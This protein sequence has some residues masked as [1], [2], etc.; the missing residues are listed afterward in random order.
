LQNA[1]VAFAFAIQPIPVFLWHYLESRYGKGC[2]I[3]LYM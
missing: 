1:A 3:A 2:L